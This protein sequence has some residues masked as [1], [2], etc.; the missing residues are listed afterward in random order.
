MKNRV[1][2]ES[3][4]FFNFNP[5]PIILYSMII[6]RNEFRLKFGKAK[7]AI[8]IWK[9]ILAEFKKSNNT[10]HLRM[11]TDLTGPAYTLVVELELKSLMDLGMKNYQWMVNEEVAKMY[12]EFV[13][14]CESAF[15]TMYKIEAETT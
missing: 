2:R 10:P 3:G 4:I 13:P 14:L 12:Q 8:D 11:L 15:R 6:E 1:G 9:R 5:K 7:E